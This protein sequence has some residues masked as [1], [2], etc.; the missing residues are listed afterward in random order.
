VIA[1]PGTLYAG[2][3]DVWPLALPPHATLIDTHNNQRLRFRQR[4]N[5]RH[6]FAAAW[7]RLLKPSVLVSGQE[8]KSHEESDYG[9]LVPSQ[10]DPPETSERDLRAI[11]QGQVVRGRD[12]KKREIL[13]L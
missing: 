6:Q 4:V 7:L 13:T 8:D 5:C 12:I 2:S 9:S 3:T 10:V 11:A 1:S